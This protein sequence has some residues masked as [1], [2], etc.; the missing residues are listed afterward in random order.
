MKKI[1]TQ[2]L[3]A[4]YLN[5]PK[6][7]C[8][9]CGSPNVYF[10]YGRFSDMCICEKCDSNLPDFKYLQQQ[11][12]NFDF[13]N[14]HCC[15][16]GSKKPR[17]LLISL[18]G[19]GCDAKRTYRMSRYAKW[20]DHYG[21]NLLYLADKNLYWNLT[22]HRNNETIQELLTTTT[23]S[24]LFR[25]ISDIS[26]MGHS[27]GGIQMASLATTLK[28]KNVIFM[29]GFVNEAIQLIVDRHSRYRQLNPNNTLIIDHTKDVGF[30]EANQ[31]LH[32]FF[33]QVHIQHHIIEVP[34][35]HNMRAGGGKM[36]QYLHQQLSHVSS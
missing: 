7:I 27:N 28:L 34:T 13:K 16:Y 26:I 8:L 14:L 32:K 33:N 21:F 15:F 35:G 23:Y 10:K 29:S 19:Y 30:T 3:T 2:K 6:K 5:I 22:Y 12:V 11:P 17:P 1:P 24:D 31:E 20:A 9:K 36:F 18:A 4:D 25:S